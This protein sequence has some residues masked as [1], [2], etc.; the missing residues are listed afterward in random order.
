MQHATL[1]LKRFVAA[2]FLS[3]LADQFLLF[4]VPL[5]IFKSTGE[6][7]YS[8]LAFVIEWIPRIVF[9]PLAGFVADRLK[10]GHLFS[11]I[12]FGRALVLI[13]A[14]ALIACGVSTFGVL[15]VMMAFLS[16]AYILSFVGSEAM[17][18][19]N[20][21][22][23]ELPKAH[24]MLQAVE[25]ITQVAGPALAALISV[26]DGLNP[27]LML[28]AAMFGT[29]SVILFGFKT[30]PMPADQ[31][32]SLRALR[33][34]NQQALKV[35]MQNKV[36]FHLSA[37]T[38]VVNLVYGAALVVSAAVVVKVFGLPE[39]RF[40]LL[41]TVAAIASIGA[42]TLVPRIARKLGLPALGISSFC[43]MI[44]AG[45]VLALSNQYAVYLVG[46]SALMACDGAFSV[47][48]RTVRSQIIPKEHLGKTTGVIGLM[49]MCSIPLSAALVTVLS[50]HFSPSGI[51]GVIFAVAATLGLALI[52]I[53]RTAFGYNTLLPPVKVN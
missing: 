5:T 45:L 19:R 29:A 22:A 10:P 42:C 15:S 11:G 23:S 21:A 33:Q 9:F 8:G 41:Q 26:W 50:A 47:Y 53:G 28:G 39:S 38:W 20:L 24:S 32:F 46:Y 1:R 3:A 14:L 35:L 40:G 51:F 31:S 52:L 49:N 25:Q 7:K 4:A 17:L 44:L 37:L 34:S 27:L 30:Q 43:A 16:I 2:R 13:I 6:L 12:E 48:I 36:L 18:P